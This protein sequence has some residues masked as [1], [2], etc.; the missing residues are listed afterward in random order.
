[1]KQEFKWY[2][3]IQIEVPDGNDDDDNEA[4]FAKAEA[5][6]EESK[7]AFFDCLDGYLDS[8]EI[9]DYDILDEEDK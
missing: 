8:G 5:V 1:M 2:V 7:N 6:Y 4:A 3:T 9:D